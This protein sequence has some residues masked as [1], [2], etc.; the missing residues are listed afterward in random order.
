MLPGGA[1][2]DGRG[3][4]P[5][6]EDERNMNISNVAHKMVI[7]DGKIDL[8]RKTTVSSPY[9]SAKIVCVCAADPQSRAT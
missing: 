9:V 4:Q 3:I 6:A 1:A 8:G 7:H 5:G 2:A